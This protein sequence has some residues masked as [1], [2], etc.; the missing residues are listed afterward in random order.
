MHLLE[1]G[2]PGNPAVLLLHGFPELAFSWRKV[3]LPLADAGYHVLAPDQ[4]GYGRTTGWDDRYDGDVHS[5]RYLNLVADLVGLLDR[6]GIRSVKAVVGHDFG[7][8]V[9]AWAAL[10][11]PELFRAVV[12]M[13]A[14]FAGQT[15]A[16]AGAKAPGASGR[17]DMQ[18]ALAALPRPRKHYM[19]YY[20]TRAA[21]QHM[22]QPP[23]G[24]HDF[25]RAYYHVKSAD[26][27]ENDPSPLDGWTAAEL[28]RLPTYYVM[29]LE[30]DMPATVEPDMPSAARIAACTWLTEAELSVY[31]REYARTGFQGGLNWYRCAIDPACTA[32]LAGWAGRKIEVPAAFIGGRQDWGVFQTPGALERMETTAC[33]D[34]RGTLLLAGAG[35][36]VQQE[37]AGAT[38]QRLLEFLSG[39]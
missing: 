31:V 15:A 5:F 32:E 9:A 33:A 8:P 12:L 6:L 39:T 29:N 23:Q 35:H 27:A 4:R 28:A 10:T 17:P 13:S 36:W 26:F 37:Q 1:A 2:R 21:D 24:L 30:Q 7:S 18:T 38:T 25:L 11:R 34:Y 14:P 22:R 3:L 20:P 19:W 16:P